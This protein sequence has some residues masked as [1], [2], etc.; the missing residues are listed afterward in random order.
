MPKFKIIKNNKGHNAGF[1]LIELMI[2]IAIIGILAAIAIPQYAAYV[3]TAR[4]S[5]VASDVKQAIDVT[6][7]AF[8]ASKTGEAENLLTNL[9]KT[10]TIGDP[11]NTSAD[12]F[13]L[14]SPTVCGQIGFSS[15]AI[16]DSSPSNVTLYIGGQECDTQSEMDLLQTLNNEGY[17]VIMPNGSI[18]ITKN[19]SVS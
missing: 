1:T 14:G 13:V 16:T 8:A 2:V 10:A 3:R 7:A 17:T 18:V 11:E 5:A 12:E 9:N 6:L 15:V 19:G 4:A